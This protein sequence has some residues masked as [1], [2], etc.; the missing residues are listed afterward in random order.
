[1]ARAKS[2]DVGVRFG[3]RVRRLRQAR[4]LSLLEMSLHSG[5]TKTFLHNVEHAKKE[6]CLRTIQTLARSFGLT[7]AQLMR[8]I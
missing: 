1:M 7:I 8:G 5:L 2:Q 3:E 4:G 6:P